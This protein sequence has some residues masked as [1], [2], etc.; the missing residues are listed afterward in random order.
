MGGRVRTLIRVVGE[1]STQQYGR[2]EVG[3]GCG[4]GQY[5][6]SLIGQHGIKKKEKK[7]SMEIKTPS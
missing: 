5:S 3:G 2:P 6:F 4:S 1:M 7:K